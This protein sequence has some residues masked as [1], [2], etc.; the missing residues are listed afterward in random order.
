MGQKIKL[1]DVEYDTDNLS[2]QSKVTIALLEFTTMRIKELTNMQLLLQRSKE[3]YTSSL[4]TEILSKK[5]GFLFG[6]D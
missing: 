5:S 4:K 6:D 2:D 3:S 1:D